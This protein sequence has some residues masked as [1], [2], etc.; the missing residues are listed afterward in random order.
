LEGEPTRPD[1]LLNLA[2][3]QQGSAPWAGSVSAVRWVDFGAR[4]ITVIA[5]PD[6][7]CEDFVVEQLAVWGHR[8]QGGG[9]VREQGMSTAPPS[10][11]TYVA[12]TEVAT[13]VPQRD[14]FISY[15]AEDHHWAEWLAWVLEENGYTTYIQ[16]WDFRPG[17][18]FVLVMQQAS[19]TAHR[20]LLVLSESFLRSL[21]PQ[22]EWAAAFATDPTGQE[23]R[24]VPVR[25]QPCQ[26]DGLLRSI[27]YID[28]VDC[29]ETE[30]ERRLLRGVLTGRAKPRERPAFPGVVRLDPLSATGEAAT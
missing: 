11:P 21:F 20:T 12:G 19:T 27:I 5:H 23:K 7:T 2:N 15:N 4:A 8:G 14:F 13:S 3:A 10:G 29:D 24:V 18:N 9:G 28:L 25:V 6:V 22:P 17:Q 16:E 30:A 1:D 26:P